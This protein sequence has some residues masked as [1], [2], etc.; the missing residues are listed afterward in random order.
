MNTFQPFIHPWEYPTLMVFGKVG[1]INEFKLKVPLIEI[2]KNQLVN[3]VKVITKI[4]IS[5]K[6]IQ[7]ID[8]NQMLRTEFN[9]GKF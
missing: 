3:K 8:E 5:I 4:A 1:D 7:I 2:R 6:I 9:K